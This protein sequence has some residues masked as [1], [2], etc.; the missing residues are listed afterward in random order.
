MDPMSFLSERWFIILLACIC[1]ALFLTTTAFL[2]VCFRQR[3]KIRKLQKQLATVENGTI[4]SVQKQPLESKTSVLI[5]ETPASQV[6]ESDECVFYDL[7]S[8]SR[9]VSREQLDADTATDP[10][11]DGGGVPK[12]SKG[13]SEPDLVEKFVQ[14]NR[15]SIRSLDIQKMNASSPDDLTGD[16]WVGERKPSTEILPSNDADSVASETV[17]AEDSGNETIS[18]DDIL[19]QN[20]EEVESAK[21]DSFRLTTGVETSAEKPDEGKVDAK[22]IVDE[23]KKSETESN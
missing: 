8:L 9:G 12:S 15:A 10:L 2:I 1:L 11:G 13:G 4:S 5:K 3:Q 21:E 17:V 14:H 22:D 23:T 18:N 19:C 20:G 16:I 7:G 6:W